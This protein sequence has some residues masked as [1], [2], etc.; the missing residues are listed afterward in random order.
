MFSKGRYKAHKCVLVNSSLVIFYIVSKYGE[1]KSHNASKTE[2]Q[3][4][5]NDVRIM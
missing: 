5:I 2:E 1:G 4:Y 3:L